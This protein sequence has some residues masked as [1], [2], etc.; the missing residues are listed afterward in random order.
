[1]NFQTPREKLKQINLPLISIFF[2]LIVIL[3]R[4]WNFGF[5]DGDFWDM[6][7]PQ[8]LSV[9]L[10]PFSSRP[11]VIPIYLLLSNL[12]GFNSYLWHL[13][14]AIFYLICGISLYRLLQTVST[15][16]N[17]NTKEIQPSYLFIA[18]MSVLCWLAFPWGL[19][20]NAWPTLLMGQISLL[21]CILSLRQY[22]QFTLFNK[23]FKTCLL[24]FTISVFTYETFYFSYL[25]LIPYLAILTKKDKFCKKR[26]LSTAIYLTIIQSVAIFQNR[27]NALIFPVGS[28]KPSNWGAILDFKNLILN[29]PGHISGA[30]SIQYRSF[31][32][33]LCTIVFGLT[34]LGLLYRLA[35]RNTRAKS[36][37]LIALLASAIIGICLSVLLYALAFYGIGSTGIMSRTTLG[38][39]M[40]LAICLFIF[41]E[42]LTFSQNIFSKISATVGASLLLYPLVPSLIEQQ[43]LWAEA[44]KNTIHII[45]SAPIDKIKNLPR[46]ASVVYVGPT[47]NASMAYATTLSL[48]GALWLMKPETRF[49]SNLQHPIFVD[50]VRMIYCKSPAFTGYFDG[51]NIVLSLPGHWTQSHASE[52]VYEWDSYRNTFK[53]MRPGEAFAEPL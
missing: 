40:W 29:L 21:F 10:I 30:I 49:P 18:D 27:I 9:Y 22:I 38:L 25:L 6:A 16:I 3:P 34:I 24:F 47:D 1:M 20:W 50:N 41:F 35:S 26:L 4:T 32:Y 2:W 31:F 33:L 12:F 7:M 44:W 39:S 37:A 51:R 17:Q 42:S 15:A 23:G 48:S 14:L 5:Y 11:I 13:F 43:K 53:K 19:G 36:F 46:S 45:Q 28:A 52:D 8:E